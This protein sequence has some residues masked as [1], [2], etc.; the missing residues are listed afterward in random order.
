MRAQYGD[1]LGVQV[2]GRFVQIFPPLRPTYLHIFWA[3]ELLLL[4]FG[5][6]LVWFSGSQ[7][8]DDSWLEEATASCLTCVGHHTRKRTRV[9][10]LVFPSI[11]LNSSFFLLLPFDVFLYLF[12]VVCQDISVVREDLREWEHFL[13]SRNGEPHGACTECFLPGLGWRGS[14]WGAMMEVIYLDSQAV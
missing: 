11:C 14:C 12:A 5:C 6:F 8:L 7:A 4:E 3:E 2:M 9:C 1:S 10:T 13:L